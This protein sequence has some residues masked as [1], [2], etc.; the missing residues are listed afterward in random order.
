MLKVFKLIK[1][2]AKLILALAIVFMIFNASAFTKLF[3]FSFLPITG[4]MEAFKS[5]EN[6]A[7]ELIQDDVKRFV[8]GLSDKLKAIT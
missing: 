2:G 8:S 7:T 5:A 4:L 3:D 6:E 1:K